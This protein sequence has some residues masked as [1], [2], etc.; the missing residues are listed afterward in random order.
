MPTEKRESLWILIVS[1]VMWAAHFLLCYITVAVWC[2]KVAGRDGLLGDARLLIAVYT[3]LAV[4]GII[5]TGWTGFR[6]H[7]YTRPEDPSSADTAPG[8]RRFLGY[9]TVLLSGLSLAAV[10]YTALAALLIR[11]CH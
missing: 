10:L 2:A 1:P 3:V 9:A 4:G 8:R 5:L 6:R 11:T 7:W